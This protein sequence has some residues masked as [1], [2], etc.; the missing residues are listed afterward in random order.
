MP[1]EFADRTEMHGF[2]HTFKD[3]YVAF[4]SNNTNGPPTIHS[5]D[6]SLK[7]FTRRHVPRK[8]QLVSIIDG[9]RYR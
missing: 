4:R 6:Y 2:E 9:F 7:Q 1:R 8:Y 5:T 3:R